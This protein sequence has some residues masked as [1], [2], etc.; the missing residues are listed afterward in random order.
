VELAH[1]TFGEGPWNI[2]PG[3]FGTGSENIHIIENFIEPDDVSRIIDFSR[4]IKRWH[5]DQLEDTYNED[6]VCTYDASYWND[7]QCTSTIIKELNPSIFNLI[8]FY[9]DKMGKTIEDIFGVEVSTRPPCII[10]WFGGIEQQPHA[11]KQLNDGSPNPFPD[12]DINSLF[13]Y[14]DDFEGGELYYPEHDI[15][16]KPKPGL[17]VLHPGDFY[18]MHGVKPVTEGERYTT[19][20]FYT[21]V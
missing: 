17:A 5:N 6:G 19:P 10:R 7:R 13:Y 8:T 20:A 16:V 3:A 1:K 14:N 21:V 2:K 4:N 18:Y 15:I 9:I 11:D 12:Y